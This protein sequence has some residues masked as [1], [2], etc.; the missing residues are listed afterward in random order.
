MPIRIPRSEPTDTPQPRRASGGF[1]RWLY[2]GTLLA[3]CAAGTGALVV[4]P[5]WV[6]VDGARAALELQQ[7]REKELTDRLDAARAAAGRLRLWEKDARRVFL[8][9][10]LTRYPVLARAIG[11][12]EGAA[13]VKAQVTQARPAR[14]RSLTLDRSGVDSGGE[15]AGE[16]RPQAVRLVLKGP[17]DGIYR[18]V[19]A[20]SQQQQ[21]FLPERWELVSQGVGKGEVRAEI[22]ATVFVVQQPGDDTPAAPVSAGPVARSV[23]LE[24]EG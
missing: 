8:A 14:W 12:R 17:F 9:E 22:W 1:R 5:Q 20:L 3:A 11:K 18:T 16:I 10:E 21:L 13:V 15:V 24:G 7:E 2:H 6:A 23:V 19:S 4:W